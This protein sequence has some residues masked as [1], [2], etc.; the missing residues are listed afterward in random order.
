MLCYVLKYFNILDASS[1]HKMK[2]QYPKEVLAGLFLDQILDLTA[3]EKLLKSSFTINNLPSALLD[4]HNNLRISI[5]FSKLCANFFRKNTDTL[6]RCRQSDS[7]ILHEISAGNHEHIV[8]SC[9]NGLTELAFPIIVNSTHIASLFFGQFFIEGKKPAPSFYTNIIKNHGFNHEG[10]MQALAEVPV[11]T[12]EKLGQII[13]YF[14]GLQLLINEMAKNGLR[15]QL[16]KHQQQENKNISEQ[17]PDD[18]CN[19]AK[20]LHHLLTEE[21]KARKGQENELQ[22]ANEE[23][24]AEIEERSV[25]EE[26][27]RSLTEELQE[28]ID[29][30]K[31]TEIQLQQSQIELKERIKELNGLNQIHELANN[32]QITKKQLYQEVAMHIPPSWLHPELTCVRIRDANIEVKTVNF[33]PTANTLKTTFSYFD[34]SEASIEI[35]YLDDTAYDPFLPEEKS[36]LRTIARILSES[37]QQREIK[38]KLTLSR[39]RYELATK[40]SNTGIWDWLV[41]SDI[42]FYSDVW[43][44]QLGYKPDELESKF[45][46]WQKLLHPED[47]DRMHQEVNNYLRNPSGYFTAEFRM[48]HKNGTYRWIYNQAESFLDNDGKVRRMI[49]AHSDITGRKLSENLLKESQE[50]LRM[51][52]EI[53]ESSVFEDDFKSGKMICSPELFKS[54]GYSE[55]EVPKSIQGMT[56]LMHPDDVPAVM[57]AVQDHF[58]GKTEHYHA[59]F[60]MKT[61][62]GDWEWADGRGRVTKKDEQGNPHILIGISRNISFKKN[63]E[64]KLADS[65]LRFRQ[66]VST[67]SSIIWFTDANG[68]VIERNKSWEDFTGQTFMTYQGAGWLRAIHPEDRTRTRIAWNKAIKNKNNFEI[69]HRLKHKSG[70]HLYMSVKSVPILNIKGNIKEWIGAHTDISKEMDAQ[71]ELEK[72]ERNYKNLFNNLHAIVENKE[73]AI[74]SV[75]LN[76]EILTINTY[77]KSIFRKAFGIELE[78][79]DPALDRLPATQDALKNKWKEFYLKAFSGEVFKTELTLEI[80]KQ[81]KYF[82]FSLNPIQEEGLVNGAVVFATDISEKHMANQKLRQS[83]ELHRSI[84]ESVTDGLI[85]FKPKGRITEVNPA[86]ARIF[87][88]SHDEMLNFSEDNPWLK[89][90]NSD[91]TKNQNKLRDGQVIHWEKDIQHPKGHFIKVDINAIGINFRGKTHIMAIARDVSELKSALK[92]IETFFEVNPDLLCTLDQEMRIENLNPAWEKSLGFPLSKIKGTG[93]YEFSHEDDREF[94]TQ[95][96]K[97][98]NELNKSCNYVCRFKTSDN[99][100]RW[101]N[102]YAVLEE[103]KI[104]AAASD[105]TEIKTTELHLKETLERLRE[106]NKELEQFAYIASHD[107]QEPLRMVS[108][109]LQLLEK[110]Y[111]E[112]LDERGIN[113]ISYAVDG[114]NRM[115]QLIKDL[116]AFSRI[117]TRGKE[118]KPTDL[119]AVL[120]QV[121]KNLHASIEHSGA[122]IKSTK[123]PQ[124]DADETQIAQLLQNLIGNAIKFHGKNPPIIRI[125]TNR[126]RKY[127]EIQV[128]DNGIGISKEYTQRIFEIFQRLH[129]RDEYEGTGIG[130]AI[131]KK[132]MDRHNGTITVES[133]LGAGSTFILRFPKPKIR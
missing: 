50:R 96:L 129:T 86:A 108:S 113:Y 104:Y 6:I 40:A 21:I 83:E 44:A 16:I 61:K 122:I 12:E 32:P 116:L 75:N 93:F 62:S 80:N 120:E 18:I 28:E 53:N 29:L 8:Y 37:L 76:F 105:I 54:L 48:K 85:I 59:E 115:Q 103:G 111:S 74:W 57:A 101:L 7:T 100:Y 114:S 98:L 5:G 70:K 41:S 58:S 15:E 119:N 118:F 22:A 43:K 121:K 91:L 1:P 2:K 84:F 65:E 124:I 78:V 52:L 81:A 88:F 99:N 35:G 33:R 127:H 123:L 14:Q 13:A 63:F 110:R 102:W 11:Y 73:I 24:Q 131:C 68:L 66:L 25:T 128:T 77:S 69:Q 27:L 46:S 87:G 130:L 132:I 23:L 90:I 19:D 82:E 31:E 89:S 107:L 95:N 4:R 125:S 72:S 45:S 64:L 56:E 92:S 17:L 126:T 47:Y 9:K 36:L 30:R 67:T 55:D 20:K 34:N 39:E 71:Q 117:G 49:G 106:S 42:V 94:I 38:K 60:R 133:I 109:F 97:S 10:F 51:S 112:K 79:G 26:E 3:I